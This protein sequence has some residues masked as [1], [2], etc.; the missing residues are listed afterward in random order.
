MIEL[1]PYQEELIADARN[2][3]ARGY[4]RIC[5][6]LACGGGKSVVAAH[7]AMLANA[8]G[9]RLL[10][11]VHR[12]ELCEQIRETFINCG[13]DM[14][15]TE[16]GM[17]QTLALHLDRISP[18]KIIICDEFH[19]ALAK[20]YRKIFD[21]FGNAALVGFTATPV[22]LNEGGLKAVCDKLITSVSTKWLIENRYL[23]PARFYSVP[24]ADMSSVKIKR[25]EYDAAQMSKLLDQR[26]VYENVLKS[27][28]RIANGKKTI[29]YCI[30]V[31]GARETAEMFLNSGYS[32]VALDGETPK[33]ERS[34]MLAKFRSGAIT[35]LCNCEL[36]GEG[37]DVPDVECIILLRKTKSLTLY[38]QQSMRCMRYVE[39]KTAVVIDHVGNIYEHGFPQDDRIWSLDEKE[40]VVNKDPPTK[41][42]PQC[43]ECLPLAAKKCPCGFKFEKKSPLEA[44]KP[45]ESEEREL[46]EIT[47][48]YM[49]YLRLQRYDFYKT[50]RSY[51]ELEAFRKARGY[52]PGWTY[53]IAKEL[54]IEKP[55]RKA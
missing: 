47:E 38:I 31:A 53:Y 1:R 44:D 15:L 28:K 10:F 17:Q 35:V 2:A 22:R 11:M 8:K 7:I 55:L 26:I 24:L 6:V 41:V 18:P 29:V 32:A 20:S 16:V 36:F 39:G 50:L 49:D 14:Q 34:E 46:M 4:K 3:L 42:C 52:K 33:I 12:K 45:E 51:E 54:G 43:S 21:H 9:N 19:H 25:G 13:V 40:K 30:S 23:S 5:I 27:Y 37:L 48:E